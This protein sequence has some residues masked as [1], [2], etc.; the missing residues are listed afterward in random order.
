MRVRILTKL[1]GLMIFVFIFSFACTRQTEIAQEQKISNEP[2]VTSETP[3]DKTQQQTQLQKLQK[4]A[5]LRL[6]IIREKE[7]LLKQRE[8]KLDSIE[9]E[10]SAREQ[11]IAESEL[12]L[13]EFRTTSYIILLIG[14]VL[15]GISLILLFKK[16][17]PSEKATRAE[18]KEQ[19]V[20]PTTQKT[21][22][23]AKATEKSTRT[24]K[25]TTKRTTSKSTSKATKD[26]PKTT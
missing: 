3:S 12:A 15:F 5:E 20:K 6:A 2:T 23:A 13:K 19:E 21:N 4:E 25:T 16:R 26:K 24:K 22:A 17:K 8:A 1:L 18:K 14:I 9:K 10:L 11:K 7:D